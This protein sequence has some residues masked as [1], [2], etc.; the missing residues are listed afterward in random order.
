MKNLDLDDVLTVVY[1][2][3]LFLGIVT[4]AAVNTGHVVLCALTAGAAVLLWAAAVGYYFGYTTN[5]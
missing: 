2:F 4:I 5:K 1:C 3:I